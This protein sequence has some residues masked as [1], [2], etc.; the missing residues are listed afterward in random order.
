MADPVITT[1]R[2]LGT[3]AYINGARASARA[4]RDVGRAGDETGAGMQLLKGSFGAVTGALG[5]LSSAAK[6]TGLI[7]GALAA[8]GAK[9]GLE[10]DSAIERSTVGMTTLTGSASEAKKVVKQVQAFALKAPMLSV[11]D[12]IQATQMLIGAGLKAKDAVPTM[13]AFSD[14]LSAMGRRPE[15]LQRMT[16]AFQQMMSKGQISAE[17]LRGQLGEIFPAS[18]LLAKGMGISMKELADKMKT[19]SLKGMKYINIL[20]SEMDKEFHGATARSAQTFSGM[21]NN[22]KENAKYTMGLVWMP[23]FKVLRDKIFPY[24][25]KIQK[26]IQKWATGGGPQRLIDLARTGFQMPGAAG[27]PTA[28]G[29]GKVKQKGKEGFLNKATFKAG[30]LFGKILPEIT[31]QARALWNALKPAKPFLDNVLLPLVEG[32]AVG[33]YKGLVGLIPVIKIVAQILGWIGTKAKPLKSVFMGI[34][35]AIGFVFGPGKL[36]IFRMF[37]KAIEFII[38]PVTKLVSWFGRV[39]KILEIVG[40]GVSR[41]ASKWFTIFTLMSVRVTD[42]VTFLVRGVGRILGLVGRIGEGITGIFKNI[43]TKIAGFIS[44]S[45]GGVISA[46][47]NFGSQIADAL[48][49]ALPAWMQK[50]L[51]VGVSGF[52]SALKAARGSVGGKAP[53]KAGKVGGMPDPRKAPPLAR[54]ASGGWTSGL[55]LVGERG[56]EIA[57]FPENTYIHPKPQATS[58]PA[59]NINLYAPIMWK[60]REVAKAVAEDT[61]DKKARR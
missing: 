52:V 4:I 33:L 53:R 18:K 45:I 8:Y 35:F 54:R 23:L 24:V 12:S 59:L 17:E 25:D 40:G 47:V 9:I 51:R 28:I 34:G 30:Q 29:G 15:D 41:L 3:R 49:N 6:S 13:T 44:A 27:A 42:F 32:F 56:P 2:I 43:G 26:G 20:L 16:Y 1:L 19:G 11:S 5:V 31:K 37:G 60:G 58:M 46:I 50:L 48:W 22:I 14:T 57:S 61:S 36:G 55:T 39:T 10:F 38:G 7:L 21:L